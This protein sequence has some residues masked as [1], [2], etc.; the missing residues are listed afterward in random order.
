MALAMVMTFPVAANT[1]FQRLLQGERKVESQ[2]RNE[3]QQVL[4]SI[5][6]DVLVRV[7]GT[8]EV[9][10]NSQVRAELRNVNDYLLQFGYRSDEEGLFLSASFD[11]TRIRQ[12]LQRA[13][14][15]LWTGRRP[16]LLLWIAENHPEQGVRLVGRAES[17]PLIEQLREASRRR[18][19]PMM[20]PL[21]DLQDQMAITPRDVWG[22]FEREI[23]DASA[24]YPTAGVVSARVFRQLADD[25]SSV[26]LGPEDES[27]ANYLPEEMEE[28]R[29]YHYILEARVSVGDMR[30]VEIIE[31]AD[32]GAL[33]T[34]FV[35]RVADRVA[36]LFIGD[37]T[38][39]TGEILVR[40]VGVNELANVLQ[41]E[42]LL[43]QQGQVY[44][45]QLRRYHQG[46]AEFAVQLNGG[47]SWLAQALEFDRRI[48]RESLNNDADIA[49]QEIALELRW[50]R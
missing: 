18:G 40:V 8:E 16:E 17:R 1:D 41:V 34:D 13:G 47:A 26:L 14:F 19:L 32:E 15:S 29:T 4:P 20:M 33:A 7:S 5:L 39:G 23:L 49:A 50:V 22:R 36:A 21:M 9:L 42:H 44:R 6:S 11:E 30:F 31:A 38:E 10:N 37:T 35:N 45:V 12:L 27:A 43:Q 28:G 2:T 46:T 3:R 48:R 25:S 24:R